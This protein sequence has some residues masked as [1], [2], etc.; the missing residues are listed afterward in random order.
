MNVQATATSNQQVAPRENL[1]L[2]EQQSDPGAFDAA[3]NA[4]L[5]VLNS[6]RE[7]TFQQTFD[8]AGGRNAKE[9]APVSSKG[10]DPAEELN[11]RV[12]RMINDASARES[13]LRDSDV[14]S[15]KGGAEDLGKGVL[16][17]E[18]ELGNKMGQV[19]A[20]TVMAEEPV[21]LTPPVNNSDTA[22]KVVVQTEE[23]VAPVQPQPQPHHNVHQRLELLLGQMLMKNAPAEVAPEVQV[24]AVVV[25]EEA[26]A[27]N[28][29]ADNQADNARLVVDLEQAA[30]GKQEAN[31]NPEP[32]K[33]VNAG[34]APNP[35]KATVVNNTAENQ[36]KPAPDVAAKIVINESQPQQQQQTQTQ[37]QPQPQAQQEQVAD[38]TRGQRESLL[39]QYKQAEMAPNDAGKGNQAPADKVE[40]AS[41][42]TTGN[43]NPS[44]AQQTTMVNEP[45]TLEGLRD[46]MVQEVRF[47][48]QSVGNSKQQAQVQLKLHPANLGELT[49]RLFF[50][51]GG[52]I[53]A[54]F[55]AAS[56]NVKE[57]LESSMQQLRT[58][59][60]GHDLKL[61]DTQVFLG[62]Y[63]RQQQEHSELNSEGR[64]N[65]VASRYNSN[66]HNGEETEA[67][68]GGRPMREVDESDEYQV[69]Y[70]V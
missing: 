60:Q 24:Q 22:P 45:V 64:G 37:Q 29:K 65:H 34:N 25:D 15:V 30:K 27:V 10:Y 12:M 9:S 28:L 39:F 57:V 41:V 56:N 36:G 8:V 35:E 42:L 51:K 6:S 19:I 48:Y 44:G 4:L 47:L 52:E 59:L 5:S 1:K 62:D 18:G 66:R 2:P 38:P 46:R 54:H 13:I 31:P 43:A 14:G 21:G 53:T 55:Y 49:V 3:V 11:R 69:N 20:E 40:P 68:D 32:V 7:Q 63:N 67:T 58:A 17:P 33:V 26:E 23:P 16:D 70:Y 50:Q 61:N